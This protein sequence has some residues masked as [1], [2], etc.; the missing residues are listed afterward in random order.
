MNSRYYY[1][2]HVTSEGVKLI[3]EFT[4][5]FLTRIQARNVSLFCKSEFSNTFWFKNWSGKPFI[6][7]CFLAT[8]SKKDRLKGDLLCLEW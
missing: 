6:H 3:K 5:H 8:V 7:S 4:G 1:S 2:V